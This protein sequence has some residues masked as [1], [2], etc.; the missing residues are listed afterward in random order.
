[1]SCFRKSILFLL[2]LIPLA[3]ISFASEKGV[4]EVIQDS[5]NTKNLEKDFIE[6]MDTDLLPNAYYRILEKYGVYS[7]EG[8]LSPENRG[9]KQDLMDKYLE[10]VL[11][12]G[13]G[14]PRS[15]A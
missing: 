12:K 7:V 11:M 15:W 3:S 8:F 13:G 2:A 5:F 9:F 4:M 1:M 10:E 14:G 6:K